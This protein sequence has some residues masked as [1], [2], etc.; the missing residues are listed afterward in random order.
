M[1]RFL[2]SIL[3]LIN[4]IQLQP[5]FPAPRLLQVYP[6]LQEQIGGGFTEEYTGLE[7]FTLVFSE[8]INP[9]S[10][11]L[12]NQKN[13][14]LNWSY[15]IVLQD[16]N[17]GKDVP[18]PPYLFSPDVSPVLREGGRMIEIPG[19]AWYSHANRAYIRIYRNGF[20]NSKG[21]ALDQDY[22]FSY[23]TC[24]PCINY[25][26]TYAVLP[27]ST[28]AV[29]DPSMSLSLYFDHVPDTATLQAELHAPDGSLITPLTYHW[30]LV[31]K[32]IQNAEGPTHLTVEHP[33]LPSDP[34]P[35]T[36]KILNLKEPLSP[37]YGLR[38]TSVLP[39]S[40]MK[41]T[42]G[43]S[44]PGDLNN[45]G[46]VTLADALLTIRGVLDPSQLTDAQRF[47]ADLLPHQGANGHTV[48]DG[49][50]DIGD[51]VWILRR[52]IGLVP[53]AQWP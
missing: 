34:R 12:P 23:A 22:R 49:K 43:P 11:I 38:Y 45:D 32:D 31:K 24:D 51:A 14:R 41:F 37:Q 30:D 5:A 1:Q 27:A 8:P 19:G 48:G 47:A 3:L 53:D 17:T 46:R 29:T 16:P 40:G 18:A 26:A 6:S 28:E 10:I 15:D 20:R 13:A 35:Y 36:F 33:P 21:E 39:E 42:V 44:L 7:P 50:V 52:A 9:Q 25:I 2:L 4:F